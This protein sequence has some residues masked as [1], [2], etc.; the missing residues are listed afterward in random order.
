[1]ADEEKKTEKKPNPLHDNPKSKPAAEAA[2]KSAEDIGDGPVEEAKEAKAEAGEDAGIAKMLDGF[3]SLVKAHESERRDLHNN[4]REAMRQ[5]HGRHEKMLKEHFG[6]MA[7]PA[8]EK[9][10]AEE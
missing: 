5:M 2:P 7:Q 8:A 1:M 10:A 3:S 9:P 4:H 6:S